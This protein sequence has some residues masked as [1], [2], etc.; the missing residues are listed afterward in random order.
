MGYKKRVRSFNLQQLT[1]KI[2]LLVDIT[3]GRSGTSCNQRTQRL[4]THSYHNIIQYNYGF[5]V[6]RDTFELTKPSN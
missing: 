3:T 1:I 4:M 6:Y 5:I 2:L